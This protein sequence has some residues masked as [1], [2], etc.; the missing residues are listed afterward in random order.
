MWKSNAL[1]KTLARPPLRRAHNSPGLECGPQIPFHSSS[2]DDVWENGSGLV[3]GQPRADYRERSGWGHTCVGLLLGEKAAAA[4]TSTCDASLWPGDDS[5]LIAASQAVE[6]QLQSQ[7]RPAERTKEAKSTAVQSHPESTAVRPHLE[8]S[9]VRPH[10]KPSAVRPHL[11]S[12]AVRPHPKPSAV[13]PQPEST[14][15]RPHPKPSAVRPHLESSAVQHQPESS[16]V[17]PH[18]ESSAVQPHLESSAVRPHPKPTAVQHQPES[19]AVRPHLESSAV[20]PESSA[21]QPESS[22]VQPE[23]SATR[24]HSKSKSKAARHQHSETHGDHA[25]S[26]SSA[27]LPP[28]TEASV[29][30]EGWVR[31]WEETN[32]I[33]AADITW[34]KE[35]PERGLFTPVQHFKDIAGQIK[36]RRVMKSDRMW[37]YPP[38]SPGYISGGLPSLQAFFRSRVF[39]WRPVGVWKYS[40]K[41]PR[42]G[43]CVGSGRNVHLYKSGYHTRVRHICDVSGWY[44]IVTEV[45]C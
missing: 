30:L 21:V 40:L 9:A 39:V 33:P 31:S 12:S 17:R 41:C 18:L 28:P 16:A 1:S 29:E 5:E 36:R 25:P 20:Q 7:S 35:D 27:D 14:A 32:G 11:E 37:F 22:A 6:D 8:S 13:R 2:C 24:P 44:T 42:G 10:P 38:E 26:T 23:S 45:L 4:A 19:S 3:R 15:V 34:L 43:E